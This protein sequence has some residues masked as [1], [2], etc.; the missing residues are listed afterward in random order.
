VKSKLR[1][2]VK[3]GAVGASGVGVNLALLYLFTDVAGLHY[4]ASAFIAIEASIISNFL[5][6]D[7]W[8]FRDRRDNKVWPRLLRFNTV[9]AAGIGV[10]MGIM[11]LLVEVAGTHYLM[12]EILAILCAFIWNYT[13]SSRFVWRGRYANV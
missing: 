13:L 7:R 1:R 2:L 5:L 6:N 8:T 3:F 9:S 4:A 11:A 12:A 10:N